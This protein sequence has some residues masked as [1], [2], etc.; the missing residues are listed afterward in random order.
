MVLEVTGWY[1]YDEFAHVFAR[2]HNPVE[3]PYIAR[4]ISLW[5]ARAKVPAAV[6]ATESLICAVVAD[7]Q[8]SLS[9][10]GLRSLYAMAVLRAVNLLLDQEQDR[11][12]A[13]S[14]KLIAKACD[15]PE[16]IITV[17]HECSHREIPDINTLRLTASD[18]IN[19]V[20][21]KYWLAQ[22][23]SIMHKLQND[24]YDTL[25]LCSLLLSCYCTVLTELSW[26]GVA[27]YRS[28]RRPPD[29]RRQ[30]ELLLLR[31]DRLWKSALDGAKRSVAV[32]KFR[33]YLSFLRHRYGGRPTSESHYDTTNTTVSSLF[34]HQAYVLTK[35]LIEG[36]AHDTFFISVFVEFVFAHFN[37]SRRS[38][39]LVVL[40]EVLGQL[41]FN[42]TVRIAAALLGVVFDL[43]DG[44]SDGD[45]LEE[46]RYF[47]RMAMFSKFFSTQGAVY[48][49]KHLGG[50]TASSHFTYVTPCSARRRV[51]S[52]FLVLLEWAVNYVNVRSDL[53][54][55]HTVVLA[56]SA[57]EDAHR[58]W[59]TAGNGL[60]RFARAIYTLLPY[61]VARLSSCDASKVV[62]QRLK[63]QPWESDRLSYALGLY[64]WLGQFYTS[65][66]PGRYTFSVLSGSKKSDMLAVMCDKSSYRVSDLDGLLLPGT[67]WDPYHWRIEYTVRCK[68]ESAC[69][70][71]RITKT[72]SRLMDHF[73]IRL[74]N[75]NNRRFECAGHQV[76]HADANDAR[77]LRASLHIIAHLSASTKHLAHRERFS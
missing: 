43:P 32:A 60:A 4:K 75:K 72:F 45:G 35:R 28:P 74:S 6:A 31:Q 46:P 20:Y 27:T 65:S 47:D 44:L 41:P 48:I 61:C 52:W 62:D 68:A 67:L 19:Y 56:C 54:P 69:L 51:N 16:Y 17:R 70:N 59:T 34:I 73:P 23:K 71:T 40:L 37:P 2:L 10:C 36:C 21:Q 77:K 3:Y 33:S 66:S 38:L 22:Y 29:G 64:V 14:L 26:S 49:Q 12:Y 57:G 9:E 15:L 76:P 63:P 1:S 5:K 53:C 39:F 11:E 30:R 7:Q 58:M 13:R 50:N 8:G 55:L 18:A 24:E 42:F 25:T